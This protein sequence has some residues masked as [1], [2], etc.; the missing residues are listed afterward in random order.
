L[1]AVRAQEAF[2]TMMREQIAPALRELG[3]KGVG[4]DVRDA[5]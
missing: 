3:L 4:P 1:A 5:V 2:V